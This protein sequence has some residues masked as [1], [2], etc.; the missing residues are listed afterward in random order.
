MTVQET[1]FLIVNADDFGL[2]AGV[3]EGI[4]TAHERGIVTSA[5][6]MV[7][8]RA[9]SEAARMARDLPGLSIGL[10]VDIGEWAFR[11]GQWV[12]NYQVV[13]AHDR[14]AVAEEVARQLLLFRQ[15]MGRDPTHLDSHQHAHRKQPLNSVMRDVARALAVPLRQFSTSVVHRPEFYGQTRTGDPLPGGFGVDRLT[16]ILRTLAP[17]YSELACHPGLR[18]DLDCPYND[19]RAEEVRILCNPRVKA[20]IAHERIRLCSF[21]RRFAGPP[22]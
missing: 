1:R 3:N 7:R 15:L 4:V 12:A 8:G 22:S 18:G 9:A 13:N 21:S 5:S 19:E 20:F 11:D 14:Q 2:S 17:G 10:H 16:E 6:L